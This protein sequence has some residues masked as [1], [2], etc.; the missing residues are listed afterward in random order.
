MKII[1][2]LFTIGKFEIG[3]GWVIL[4]GEI[5]FWHLFNLVEG[6]SVSNCLIDLAWFP[7]KRILPKVA[8]HFPPTNPSSINLR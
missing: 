2:I 3:M 7:Q 6:V 1:Q 8:P 5:T 4:I